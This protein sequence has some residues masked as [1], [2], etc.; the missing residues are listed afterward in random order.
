MDGTTE[1]IPEK[2][3][4]QREAKVSTEERH[5]VMAEEDAKMLRPEYA[6]LIVSRCPCFMP[7]GGGNRHMVRPNGYGHNVLP[8]GEQPCKI[9]IEEAGSR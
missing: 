7:Y 4:N 2:Y 5:R 3:Y 1:K 8:I 9:D 6:K